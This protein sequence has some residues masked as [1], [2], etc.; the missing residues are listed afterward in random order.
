MPLS[1]FGTV[2]GEN[3]VVSLH[4]KVVVD[5]A[6][7]VATAEVGA[8]EADDAAK[9]R[10][11]LIHGNGNGLTIFKTLANHLKGMG[12][13]TEASLRVGERELAEMEAA[14]RERYLATLSL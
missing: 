1:T 9:G 8:G 2:K 4:S 3:D 6:F 5:E 12:W 7:A 11:C 14:A 13:P 10:P